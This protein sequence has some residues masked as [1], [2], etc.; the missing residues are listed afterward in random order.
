MNVVSNNFINQIVQ[1]LSRVFHL[2]FDIT[3]T[4]E[5]QSKIETSKICFI[6]LHC[7]SK[8]VRNCCARNKF[9]HIYT[10]KAIYYS[11]IVKYFLIISC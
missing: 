9:F 11:K 2:L 5:R 6:P 4:T 10:E 8:L 1:T 3:Y 7:N